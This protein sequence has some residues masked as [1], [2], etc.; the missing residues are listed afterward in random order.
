MHCDG[1]RIR[2]TSRHSRKGHETA[3]CRRGRAAHDW[4]TAMNPF[5]I[6]YEDRFVRPSV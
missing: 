5:A 1:N 2:D 4:K 3:C 6:L